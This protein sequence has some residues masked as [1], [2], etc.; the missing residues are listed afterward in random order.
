M[1]MTSTERLTA[2]LL[3]Q[4]VDHL[5]FSPFLAYVW[6]SFPQEVQRAGIRAFHQRIGADPLWR[7]APCPIRVEVDGVETRSWAENGRNHVVQETPVGSLHSAWRMTAQAG[8]TPFLVEHPLKTEADYKTLLWIEEHTRF[9]FDPAPA[10]Q[11][12]QAD[13]HDGLCL[14]MLVHRG[15]T[16]FQSMVEHYCGTEELAVHLLDEFPD[17]VET[18]WD[19]MRKNNERCA[20]CAAQ[21]PYRFWLTFEDSSTQNYS[22]A[23]YRRYIAPEITAYCRILAAHD[24]HY[25]QHACGHLNGLVTE[26]R[27]NGVLAVESI[28]EPPTGDIT[29]AEARRRVGATMGIVGG[30]EPVAFLHT[31]YE[32]FGAYVEQIID[33][34]R[35]GPFVLA[36]SDS[37]PPGVTVEKYALAAEIAR[38]TA[39]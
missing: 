18:L 21:G 37:C 8:Q 23:M 35:G 33:D 31:P 32:R 15:K 28:S 20:E 30:I 27:D 34:A 14:G 13:G 26:M 29:I 1:E 7:G 2:A 38:N 24:K 39:W 16:A 22:P 9:P 19:T 25:I 11:F 5:P 17:T 4:P 12:L 3:G 10:D 36:N 6:E